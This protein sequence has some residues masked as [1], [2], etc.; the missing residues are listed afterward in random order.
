MSTETKDFQP[1]EK[2]RIAISSRALFCPP[3]AID[4]GK[5]C[6][7]EKRW[8]AYCDSRYPTKEFMT[9]KT[10]TLEKMADCSEREFF[11]LAAEE[12]KASRKYWQ[13]GSADWREKEE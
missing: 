10:E 1:E 4:W 11:R 8:D 13:N 7:A 12:V 2:A 9:P 5:C 6:R 3:G